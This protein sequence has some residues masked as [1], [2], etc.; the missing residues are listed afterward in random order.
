M[1]CVIVLLKQY[2][3]DDDD[4]RY[5][6]IWVSLELCNAPQENPQ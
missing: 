4:D 6:A 1:R 2:D 3:D 5:L